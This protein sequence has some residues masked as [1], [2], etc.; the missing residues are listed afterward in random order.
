MRLAAGIKD[1]KENDDARFQTDT[2]PALE[3]SAD[4]CERDA[5]SIHISLAEIGKIVPIFLVVLS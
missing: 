4:A 3:A 1:D 5:L 2:K